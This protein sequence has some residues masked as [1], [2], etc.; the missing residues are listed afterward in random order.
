MLQGAIESWVL[1]DLFECD[2]FIHDKREHWEHGVDSRVAK[3]QEPVVD[4]YINEEE[5]AS[6]DG[7]DERDDHATMDNEL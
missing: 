5:D 1:F 2:I 4:R 3:N 6:K 7:L